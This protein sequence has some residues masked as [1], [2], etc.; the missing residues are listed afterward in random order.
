MLNVTTIGTGG[1]T[2]DGFFGVLVGKDGVERDDKIQETWNCMV[3][4]PKAHL[5]LLT[6]FSY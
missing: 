4:M 2:S 5:T 1:P 6:D 3:D